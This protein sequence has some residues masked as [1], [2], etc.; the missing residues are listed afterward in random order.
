MKT[1]LLFDNTVEYVEVLGPTADVVRLVVVV[2][3]LVVVVV[4]LVVVVVRLVVVVVGLGNIAKVTLL[5][6]VTVTAMSPVVCGE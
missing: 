4:R 5:G 3:R 1:A 2:V 6:P